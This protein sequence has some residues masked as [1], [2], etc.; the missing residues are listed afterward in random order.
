MVPT[1]FFYPRVL[2]AL[3]WRLLRRHAVWSS[4]RRVAGRPLPLPLTPPRQRAPAPTPFAGLTDTPPGAACEPEATPP[5]A[6]PADQLQAGAR[7][8][9]PDVSPPSGALGRTRCRAQRRPGRGGPCGRGQR[10]PGAFASRG[11][12]GEGPR[13]P[14]APAPRGGRAP[15]G[16]GPGGRPS[17]GPGGRASVGAPVHDGGLA[18]VHDRVADALGPRGAA[19]TPPGER[20]SAPAARE[21]TT[22]GPLCAGG[23][24]VSPSPPGRQA[25]PPRV[26]DARGG[27]AGLS[28]RWWAPHLSRYRTPAPGHPPACG[29]R[30]PSRPHGVHTRRRRTPAVRVVPP[31]ASCLPAPCGVTPV[32]ATGRAA[33]QE[34]LRAA[35]APVSASAGGG[36]HRSRVASTRGVTL[37]RAAMAPTT[38]AVSG[39]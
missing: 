32:P 12:G 33:P 8:F 26:R 14:L 4:E 27:R 19:R 10:A 5:K 21:A 16:P 18:G 34:G 35:G 36:A 17:R 38:G 1:V 25:P 31:V 37:P 2:R 3:G 13:A 24:T 39:T 7:D 28:R 29:R 9:L 11:L 20:A 22:G 23:P 6:P 30:G 15:P